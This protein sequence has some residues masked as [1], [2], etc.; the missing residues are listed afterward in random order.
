MRMSELADLYASLDLTSARTYIQ[1]GNVVFDYGGRDVS[2]LANRIELGLKDQLH[3]DAVV[4]LR[5]SGEFERVVDYTPLPGEDESKLHVTF[6]HRKPARVPIDEINDV[7][8]EGEA[9]SISDREV[10]LSCPNGYGVTKLSNSFL[11]G[12]LKVPATTR[13]W[14]TVKALN[15]MA[16]KI[17]PQ[18]C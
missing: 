2:N 13:N 7:A 1:S 12:V 4:F 15:D 17:S 16:R 3:V 11:E 10:Y 9:F 18:E 5:T 6:L 14:K 8:G